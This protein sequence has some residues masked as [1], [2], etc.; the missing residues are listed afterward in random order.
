MIQCVQRIERSIRDRSDVDGPLI[1]YWIYIFILFL[2]T[3]GI[4]SIVLFFQRIGRID[5]F[6]IRK[7]DYYEGVIEF[8]EKYSQEQDKYDEFQNEIEDLK[9]IYQM[10]FFN[11]IKE[12]KAGMSFLLAIVTI[13]IYGFIVLYKLNKVWNDLQIFERNFDDRLSQLLIKLELSTY[14]L[15]FKSDPTK[16]RSFSMYLVLGFVTFGIWFI[17]WDYKI[18]TD[19]DN[20]YKEFHSVEDTI[21]N[22][23]RK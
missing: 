22:I 8:L 23:V 19:P 16:N 15:T 1:N 18:H 3:F 4:Y 9:T 14:P 17:V 12:I 13:G 11:N 21:L 7:R 10:E 2:L 6:I 20:L 5:K